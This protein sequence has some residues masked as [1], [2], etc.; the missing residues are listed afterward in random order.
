M[1]SIRCTKTNPL[2]LFDIKSG[3]LETKIYQMIDCEA[4]AGGGV[5]NSIEREGEFSI[6]TITTVIKKIQKNLTRL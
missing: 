2:H 1:Y 5:W 4:E 6:C 3:K